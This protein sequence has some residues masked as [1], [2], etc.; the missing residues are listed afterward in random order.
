MSGPYLEVSVPSFT[1]L[2]SAVL[3][4]VEDDNPVM[5]LAG[6]RF[7]RDGDTAIAEGVT[8]GG[9]AHCREILTAA[10]EETF[11]RVLQVGDLEVVD[12]LVTE[13]QPPPDATVRF[14]FLD[15]DKVEVRV[16]SQAL[17]TS[18]SVIVPSIT[19]E[20]FPV[21]TLM[22]TALREERHGV[23]TLNVGAQNLRRLTRSLVRYPGKVTI[24]PG[25]RQHLASAGDEL[26]VVLPAAGVVHVEKQRRLQTAPPP[27][28]DL[29]TWRDRFDANDPTD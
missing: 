14:T 19:G 26:L 7:T 29:P 1:A 10:S 6:V 22:R 8:Q 2:T 12:I 3:P 18:A 15:Q 21:A 16:S 27:V 20:D 23:T 11:D 5:R 25:R 24:H 4:F 28:A 13:Q 17:G 9:A